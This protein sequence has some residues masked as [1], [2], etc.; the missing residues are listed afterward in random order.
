MK[1]LAL[2]L[3]LA[4]CVFLSNSIHAQS[5]S[6]S[7]AKV[8]SVPGNT[9]VY[10]AGTLTAANKIPITGYTVDLIDAKNN[11]V[12]IVTNAPSSGGQFSFV[13]LVPAGNQLTA[14][15]TVKVTT[16]RQAGN[17]SPAASCSCN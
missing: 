16:N 5:V 1:K 11:T 3:T 17:T 4:C 15:Y 12:R 8:V 14:P 6:I 13:G 9:A 10:V 7:S 2:L